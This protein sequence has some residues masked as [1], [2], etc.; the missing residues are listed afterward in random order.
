MWHRTALSRAS[1]VDSSQRKGGCH[2]YASL[3]SSEEIIH[4]LR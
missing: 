4:H 3:R 2:D 1:A